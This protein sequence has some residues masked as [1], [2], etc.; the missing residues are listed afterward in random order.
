MF[1]TTAYQE[2]KMDRQKYLEIIKG[3]SPLLLLPGGLTSSSNT[4]SSNWWK[5]F[6]VRWENTE[7]YCHEIFEAMPLSG[8]S[9]RPT[10]EIKSFGKLFSHIGYSLKHLCGCG[11]R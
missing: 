7:K 11:E 9:Y 5:Q 2:K 10:P 3:S 8:F 1:G 6:Q 4:N